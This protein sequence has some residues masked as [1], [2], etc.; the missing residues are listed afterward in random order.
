[1]NSHPERPPFSKHRRYYLILKIGVL[2][3][4][5]LLALN[6]TGVLSI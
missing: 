5:L 2:A 3:L 6:V 4:A 1:M